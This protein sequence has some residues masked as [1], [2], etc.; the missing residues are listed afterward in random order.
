MNIA[1]GSQSQPNIDEYIKLYTRIFAF[2]KPPTPPPAPATTSISEYPKYIDMSKFNVPSIYTNVFGTS[3]TIGGITPK[4]K[5]NG[6]NIGDGHSYVDFKIDLDKTGNKLITFY[7]RSFDK[8]TKKYKLIQMK[9]YFDTATNSWK[10]SA[11][12]YNYIFTAIQPE[13]ENILEQILVSPERQGGRPDLSP[14]A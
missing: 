8:T 9:Y 5:S 11:P 12:E 3:P 2:D 7:R 13:L 14:N 4:I 10:L 6:I 1:A